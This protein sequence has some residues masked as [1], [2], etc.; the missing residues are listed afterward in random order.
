MLLDFGLLRR[1]TSSIRGLVDFGLL[2]RSTSSIRGLVDFGLLRRSTS[3]IRG[4]VDFGLLRRSR[5]WLP[6]SLSSSV[7]D[8]LLPL[9]S[10]GS[11]RLHPC[12]RAWSAVP[13][14][15][16]VTLRDRPGSF[17]KNAASVHLLRIHVEGPANL[18]LFFK[19]VESWQPIVQ[20]T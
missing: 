18:A 13:P 17:M 7:P 9:P 2:R 14:S 3:S 4:L 19:C 15:L 6:A 12:R 5:L 11:Y 20:S 8:S 16:A 1:S 10:M